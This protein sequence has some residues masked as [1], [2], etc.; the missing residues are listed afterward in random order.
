MAVD[1]NKSDEPTGSITPSGSSESIERWT[2][3]AY[4]TEP[5]DH[6]AAEDAVRA[7]Y[8]KAA[9]QAPREFVWCDS[10]AEAAQFA[11]QNEGSEYLGRSLREDVRTQP[12]HSVRTELVEQLGRVGW[13]EAWQETCGEITPTVSRL[14][15]Q[16]GNA[17]V[18]HRRGAAE[19]TKLRL[20]L[21]FADHGQHNAAWL[22]LFEP[23][24]P[25]LAAGPILAALTAV[26]EQVHWWWPFE[27]VAILCERPT[28]LHL[29]ERGRLHNGDGPALA[30]RDG[31]ALHRWRGVTI[32]A[33]FAQ[34]LASLTPTAIRTE[35]NAELRRIMLEHYGHERYIL[36]SGAEPIQQDEAGKLWRVALPDDEAITMVEVVNST[37]E[38]D[39][40]FRTY[41]LR[42]PP[43]MST[44]KQAVAWTFGLE[45]QE[46]EPQ[47]QT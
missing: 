16:T 27:N 43:H 36:D 25:K 15:E 19:R 8:E 35:R 39:G 2:G 38:P 26:A 3:I 32:P 5:V 20:A 11:A 23:Y 17:V 21:T 47:I 24:R 18:A 14:I 40:T 30:Y 29:D 10:P 6:S 34:T 45:E 22:P 46:Y 7:L 4:N 1:T 42:V 44:A 31:F 33:E 37:A 28:E 12:W 13:N 41:W 9:G